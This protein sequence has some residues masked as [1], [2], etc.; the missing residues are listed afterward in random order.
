M[1]VPADEEE[2]EGAFEWVDMVLEVGLLEGHYF[3]DV[4]IRRENLAKVRGTCA[5]SSNYGRVWRF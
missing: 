4:S 2:E 1:K 5:G 3:C